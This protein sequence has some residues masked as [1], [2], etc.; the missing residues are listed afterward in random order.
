MTRKARKPDVRNAGRSKLVPFIPGERPTQR[1][2]RRLET[3]LAATPEL[4]RWTAE[5][6]L[7]LRICNQGHHW[8][9][10]RPG[11]FAEWW[12]SSAKLVLFHKYDAGIHTHDHAQVMREIG[13]RL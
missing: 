9:F 6:G 5:K 3:N 12:P 8:I 4:A 2:R 11:F 13:R 1:H 7:T 10:E